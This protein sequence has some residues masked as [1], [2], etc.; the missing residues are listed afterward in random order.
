MA[1]QVVGL[2][3]RLENTYQTK[4]AHKIVNVTAIGKV[5]PTSIPALPRLH[6]HPQSRAQWVPPFPH[7]VIGCGRSMIPL[8]LQVRQQGI[9]TV[10]LQDPR[11]SPAHFDLVIAPDHDPVS[12]P[13][14]IKTIGS[15]HRVTQARLA[16]EAPTIHAAKLT[17]LPPLKLG[18]LIG[19]D[20]KHMSLTPT[21]AAEIAGR[22]VNLSMSHGFSL[23]VT[24]S[25]RTN[26]SALAAL[27]SALTPLPNCFFWDGTGANPYFD[28][29]NQ[30]DMLMVTE[31]SV[32]MTS[33][34]VATGKPVYIC[35]LI[36]NRRLA[37]FLP[38]KQTLKFDKFHALLLEQGIT[39]SFPPSGTLTGWT[40]PPLDPADEA[41]EAVYNLLP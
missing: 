40:Y 18:V 32:N 9:K 28:I 10:Y 17:A 1:N 27:R 12:G 23:M 22:L 31:D 29:L 25:R 19:G 21:R 6:L 20:N 16:S 15:I 24:A 3:E 7:M 39:R 41:L 33:E 14:V 38:P 13:N 26:Q 37:G 5:W 11:I 4:W 8:L 2:C 35:D 34:A 36:R 30:A